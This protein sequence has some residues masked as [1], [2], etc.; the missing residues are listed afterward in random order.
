MDIDSE[1]L[2]D[3]ESDSELFPYDNETASMS[4]S[5]QCESQTESIL[6]KALEEI[7]CLKAQLKQK[8]DNKEKGTCILFIILIPNYFPQFSKCYKTF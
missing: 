7:E 1:L 4:Q 6:R 8:S 5:G 3:S 2:T